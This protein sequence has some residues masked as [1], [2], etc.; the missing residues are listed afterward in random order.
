M[1]VTPRTGANPFIPAN[2][3]RT[4]FSLTTSESTV[5]LQVLVIRA[6]KL[7]GASVTPSDFQGRAMSYLLGRSG[8][9]LKPIT[10]C[11]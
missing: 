8:R 9:A 7:Q 3:E 1:N 11:G 5:V 4:R 6:S 2:E 10:L